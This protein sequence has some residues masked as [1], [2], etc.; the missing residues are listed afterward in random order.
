M[1]ERSR[2]PWVIDSDDLCFRVLDDNGNVVA[3]CLTE[4][5]PN[6]MRANMKLIELAPQMEYALRNIYDALNSKEFRDVFFKNGGNDYDG[7]KI[8][9]AKIRKILNKLDIGERLESK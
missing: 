9:M 2:Y 8:D 6:E 7:P 3:D 1:A 5:H 4:L